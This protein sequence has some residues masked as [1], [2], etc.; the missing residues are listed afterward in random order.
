MR[1]RL[2]TAGNLDENDLT[3]SEFDD[4]NNIPEKDD[5]T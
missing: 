1:P 3:S 2:T 5:E 4:F